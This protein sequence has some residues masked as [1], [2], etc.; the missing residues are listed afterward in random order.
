MSFLKINNWNIDWLFATI[1]VPICNGGF[2][3]GGQLAVHKLIYITYKWPK[4]CWEIELSY[5]MYCKILLLSFS[6]Y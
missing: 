2:N 3:Y 1:L 5:I 4:N 6:Y